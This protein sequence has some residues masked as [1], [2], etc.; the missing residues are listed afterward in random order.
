[1]AGY[2]LDA[3]YFSV[4]P[5]PQP[6]PLEIA[7]GSDYAPVAQQIVSGVFTRVSQGSDYDRAQR[8][9]VPLVE[10]ASTEG[11]KWKLYVYE[12]DHDEGYGV[13]DGSIFVSRSLIEHLD[14]DDELTAVLAHLM[15]H[16]RYGHSRNAITRA[17]QSTLEA[18][19]ASPFVGFAS[20][21]VPPMA[22]YALVLGRDDSDAV[23][24]VSHETWFF[25]L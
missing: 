5:V 21:L 25:W 18:G 9:F 23:H 12:S 10:V 15:A 6:P 8:A 14:S 2:D 3:F 24:V 1:V 20:L 11:L 19:A 4:P 22:P 7:D 17:N 13:P 16:E